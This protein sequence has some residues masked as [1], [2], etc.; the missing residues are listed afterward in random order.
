MSGKEDSDKK[1]KS[2]K[3]PPLPTTNSFFSLPADDPCKAGHYYKQTVDGTK[4]FCQQ[5]GKVKV[6]Q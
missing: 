1:S 4:L 5:C 2:K 6:L 3:R